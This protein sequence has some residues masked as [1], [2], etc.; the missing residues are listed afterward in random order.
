MNPLADLI[1]VAQMKK[2]PVDW[3][4]P[5]GDPDAGH[6]SQHA[7]KPDE[8][9]AV[10]EP[11][12][13]FWAASVNKYHVDAAKDVGKI[14]KDFVHTALD[15]TKT[16]VDMWRLQAKV[17]DLKV[18][19]VCAIGAPGC[20][21]GPDLKDMPGYSTWIGTKDNEKAY[22]K[23]VVEGVTE[24]WKE[25]SSKCMCPGL[26]LYPAFAAYPL[27]MAVPTPSIPVPVITL[28]S[29]GMA[30]MVANMLQKAMIDK[31]DSK[32][33][34][35]DSDKQYE[36]CFLAIG[37]AIGTAF[38]AWLPMQQVMNVLGKGPIPPYAP[39]YIPVGPVVA[40]DNLAIPG[41]LAA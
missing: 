29:A 2:L 17:K 10:P 27:A 35:E 14:F 23:A 6:Y 36:A 33:K 40:G 38:L 11:M 25:W 22:I 3:K 19:S 34:D 15:N 7:F 31:L 26:P 16:A 37:T 4:Q 21:D 41:H 28:V 8:K 9:A 24:C 13:Y 18:M 32:V 5:Q 1:F 12:C 30:K 20:L 39:P